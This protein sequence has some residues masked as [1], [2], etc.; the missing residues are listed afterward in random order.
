MPSSG[1][2]MTA[3]E[4]THSLRAGEIEEL[5]TQLTPVVAE[6]TDYTLSHRARLVRPL[7][8]Y[9]AQALALSFV[10]ATAACT[11]SRAKD[12]DDTYSYHHLRRDLFTRVQKTR[13]TVA[14]RYVFPSAHITIARFITNKDFET[15]SGEVDHANV[16]KLIKAIDNVNLWLA[17]EYWP[18]HGAVKNGGEWIVGEEQGL[19]CRKGTLWY[20]GGGQT[21]RLGKGF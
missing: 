2:H 9:D 17:K 14:S 4:I 7:L 6:I 8:S 10:P 20:G 16:D 15:E 5:V 3:L 18:K 21:V 11:S 19:D 13:V 1:L 12:H